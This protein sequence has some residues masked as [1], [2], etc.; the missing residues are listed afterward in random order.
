MDALSDH[1]F[2]S[3]LLFGLSSLFHIL[4]PTLTIGLS[5]FLVTVEALWLKTGDPDYY[6]HARFWSKLF[7]LNFGIG[8]VSGLPLQFQLGTNWGPYAVATGEF[9][10]NILGFEA[11]MAFMLE[12]GFLGI[13]LFGWQRVPRPMHLFATA[14]VAFGASLSAFWIMAANAWMQTPTGAHLEGQRVVIDSYFDAIFNPD[15]PWAVSHM[16]VACLETSLFV[17]GGISAW[18][19]L[20]NRQVSFFFKA[21]RLAFISAILIA[22]LQILLGDM[23]GLSVAKHQPAKLAAME[24]HWHTN[25]PGSGAAWVAFAWPD[26]E[27]QRN[28]WALEIP[29]LLSLIIT[30]SPHGEVKGLREFPR[31][32]RAPVLLPFYALRI[33]ILI[34]FVLFALMLWTAWAWRKGYLTPAKITTQRALLRAWIAAIPL[35]YI[36]VDAGWITREVGR[37]PWLVQGWLR[38]ADMASTLPAPAVLSTL[39]AYGL[40]YSGLF[41]VFLFLAIRLVRKGPDL[42]MADPKSAALA[43]RASAALPGAAAREG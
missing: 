10:G 33:M 25:P 11:S 19:I 21:F 13:M 2:L 5:I 14:M 15:M 18:Y 16:W 23:S 35:G 26:E 31:T 40:V 28:R 34:G 4:W 22:P 30:H 42:A 43:Q 6:H 9:I 20:R 24:S 38:T 12:A 27:Q 32:E 36:A 7:A 39:L 8:I 3:R 1:V 17:I 37:Q 41:I 29:Y